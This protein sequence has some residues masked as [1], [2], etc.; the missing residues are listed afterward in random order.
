VSRFRSKWLRIFPIPSSV[1][2]LF[3]VA[4][5]PKSGRCRAPV[6]EHASCP[7]GRMGALPEDP[8]D[9]PS[10]QEAHPRPKGPQPPKIDTGPAMGPSRL[11]VVNSGGVIGPPR[12]KSWRICHPGG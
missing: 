2:R 4:R 9:P 1:G 12:D 10:G 7:S 8:A 5:A 6:A 11:S 3:M